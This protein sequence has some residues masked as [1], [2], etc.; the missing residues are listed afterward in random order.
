MI[1]IMH[2]SP[3]S[4]DGTAAGAILRLEG[5]RREPM[6]RLE[7]PREM[8]LIGEPTF[9]GNPRG[10]LPLLEEPPRARETHLRVIA[11]GRKSNRSVER[12]LEIRESNAGDGL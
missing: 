2:C 8:R 12:A 4:S 7:T 1:E 9:V 3:P 10:G 6:A 5:A 11:P